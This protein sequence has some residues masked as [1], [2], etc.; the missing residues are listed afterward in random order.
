MFGLLH[1]IHRTAVRASAAVDRRGIGHGGVHVGAVHAF[2]CSTDVLAPLRKLG[3]T[4]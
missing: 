4:T 1:N 2:S 3:S